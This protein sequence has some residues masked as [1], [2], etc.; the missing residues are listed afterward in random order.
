MP[1]HLAVTLLAL[2]SLTIAVSATET[3]SARPISYALVEEYIG[4]DFLEGF[5]FEAIDDPTHGRVNYVNSAIALQEQLVLAKRDSFVLRAD[6]KTTL[7]PEGPGRNSVR[8]IS[9]N[10][11]ENAVMVF[12]V[13]HMPEGC[14]SWPAVWTVGLPWPHL[15]EI[16]I[17]EGVNNQSPNNIV[18]HTTDGCDMPAV[19]LQT[20]ISTKNSCGVG[21]D[22]LGCPVRPT[23]LKSFGPP[24]NQNGGGWYAM[25]RT[26]AFIKVWFWPRD[27]SETPHDIRLGGKKVDT[28]K[29]GVPTAYFPSSDL[30]DLKSKFGPNYIIINLTFCGD[31]AGKASAYSESGCPSTC[32]DFVNNNP[33]AFKNAF[34]DFK[35]LR[36]YK[37]LRLH[38]R[39]HNAPT[40][41]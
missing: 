39:H 17:I 37:R 28:S 10:Q 1:P 31:W 14:G 29:W 13:K 24:F 20:G 40:V 11:Y 32:V 41:F 22:N 33:D 5:N 26:D 9:K 12:D 27:C 21:D 35:A 4:K 2:V 8:L 30:C 15:G 18:L 3:T 34:F 23:D 25:E 6:S 36:V 16:D 19:R 7:S 38:S